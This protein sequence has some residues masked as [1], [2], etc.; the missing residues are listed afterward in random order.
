MPS[1]SSNV[2]AL[3]KVTYSAYDPFVWLLV[4]KT[5]P[6]TREPTRTC[7]TLD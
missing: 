3:L 5:K 6:A 1:G 2:T 4:P 7:V